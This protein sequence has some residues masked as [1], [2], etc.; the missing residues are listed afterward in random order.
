[1]KLRNLG[2]L[3]GAAAIAMAAC[4]PSGGASTGPG[5]S[6]AASSGGTG[7]GAQPAACK[8]KAGKSTSEIHIYS[9]LPL[10]GTSLEQTSV[11]VQEI[12][13]VL[14]GQKVGNF[15]IKYTSLDDASPAKNGDWDGTVEQSN[16]N[17]AANAPDTRVY[18]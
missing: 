9:S 17:K 16:A 5:G 7:T 11:M 6:G 12:K 18:T 14:D 13:T 4:N 1:M 8:N 10:E 15:T 3:V 2:V